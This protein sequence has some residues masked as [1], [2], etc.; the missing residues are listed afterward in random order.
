MAINKLAANEGP[1][2]FDLNALGQDMAL[3]MTMTTAPE[4]GSDLT[5]I[6]FDGTFHSPNGTIYPNVIKDYAPRFAHSHSN[7]FFIH[8]NTFNSLLRTAQSSF[9]PIKIT[10]PTIAG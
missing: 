7:Q 9:F 6:F 8:Q 10:D 2:T 1:Y 4:V 3:N 5:K